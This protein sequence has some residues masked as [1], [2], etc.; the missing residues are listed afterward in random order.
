MTKE[1]RPKGEQDEEMMEEGQP[2]ETE[3]ESV[4]LVELLTGP[5]GKSG[6]SA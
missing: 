5:E 4:E 1:E 2:P 6:A 3:Y